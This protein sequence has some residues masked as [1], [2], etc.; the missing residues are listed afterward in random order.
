MPSP[1]RRADEFDLRRAGRLRRS[2]RSILQ[3]RERRKNRG[4]VADERVRDILREG[5]RRRR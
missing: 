4:R 1:G 5:R 3:A 2:I